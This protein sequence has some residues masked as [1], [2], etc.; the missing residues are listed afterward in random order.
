MI[1]MMRP[2]DGD[3]AHETV[4]SIRRECAETC[5]RIRDCEN[6]VGAEADALVAL[7]LARTDGTVADVEQALSILV[8]TAARSRT[9]VRAAFDQLFQLGS[10]DVN[11]FDQGGFP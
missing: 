4:A 1:A 6:A 5:R 7:I 2:P 9:A 11:R 8:A 3:A 10:A